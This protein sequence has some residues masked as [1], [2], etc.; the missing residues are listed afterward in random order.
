MFSSKLRSWMEA[1]RPRKKQHRKEK[2][3]KANL[4]TTANAVT[5]SKWQKYAN[6]RS[7]QDDLSVSLLDA[8][9]ETNAMSLGW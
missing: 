7:S 4:N 5:P 8:R 3:T 2:Q 9:Q 6:C 1:V